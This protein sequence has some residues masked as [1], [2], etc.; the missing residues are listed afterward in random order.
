MHEIYDRLSA[1]YEQWAEEKCASFK[2]RPLE[3]L[4]KE[5]LIEVIH[6]RDRGYYKMMANQIRHCAFLEEVNEARIA[7]LKRPL[8]WFWGR[9]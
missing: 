4:T 8:R 9:A 5:E 6:L 7:N 1:Q 3:D 2:G